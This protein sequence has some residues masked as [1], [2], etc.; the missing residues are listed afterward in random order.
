MTMQ[1][2]LVSVM[3]PAYNADKYIGLAI[4]SVLAQT[5]G[6]WELLV[7][8]DGSTDRTVEVV[9]RFTDSRIRLFNK[10]NGGESTARN[11]A[12]DHARGELIAYLDADDIYLPDHLAVT[13]AFLEENKERGAVYTDGGHIDQNGSR[14]AS[15]QSRRRGP[16]E[17]RIFEEVVRASDV[18]GP[19]MCVVL[20]HDTVA[21]HHL[22]YDPSIV[23]GPDWDFF[24]RYADLV[25]F[26]YL[27]LVTGLYR[28]HE[29][30]IT[31]QVGTARRMASIAICREKSIKM[32]SFK[33]CSADTRAAVFY[34]LMVDLLRGLPERQDAVT[35]W[36]EF[37]ELPVDEQGRLLR[38]MASDGIVRGGDH[39]MLGR[40]LRKARALNP[41][42]RR[43]AVLAAIF[44]VSPRA[45][46]TLL[47][48]RSPFRARS[49]H[50]A[51]FG[52][53]KRVTAR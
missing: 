28:V 10:P 19:P 11:M 31:S 3:M 53:L 4:E 8:N 40:W 9:S 17:G 7:V 46:A 45:C 22:R 5:Y 35:K 14:L 52:D 37:A 33:T 27:P 47:S 13:V 30:N 12:L 36:A 15:L 34:D 1:T 48:L 21:R 50:D 43:A 2:G 6:N 42:D 24:I 32:A 39:R 26:G 51:P 41:A 23:I 29:S 38:L 16:F 25:T 44:M 49:G 20:R 18:F